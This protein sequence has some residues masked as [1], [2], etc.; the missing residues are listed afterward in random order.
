MKTPKER[1]EEFVECGRKNAIKWHNLHTQMAYD[2]LRIAN[3]VKIDA[4]RPVPDDYY[5][6]EKR[7]EGKETR[8]PK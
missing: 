7:E 5:D 1:Y 8:N 3:E 2:A 6:K 4:M